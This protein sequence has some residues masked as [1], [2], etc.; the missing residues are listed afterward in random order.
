[1]ILPAAVGPDINSGSFIKRGF[2][3]EL[4]V[5]DNGHADFCYSIIE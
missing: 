4:K 5:N 2:I 3:S 1:M